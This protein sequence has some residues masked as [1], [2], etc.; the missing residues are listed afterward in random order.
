M[1]ETILVLNNMSAIETTT[2]GQGYEDL[3]VLYNLSTS[4]LEEIFVGTNLSEIDANQ[5]TSNDVFGWLLTLNVISGLGVL[6]NSLLAF[7]LISDFIVD[8]TRRTLTRHWLLLCMA[9]TNIAFLG[10]EIYIREFGHTFEQRERVCLILQHTDKTIEFVTVLYLVVVS[11]HVVGGAVRPQTGCG[12]KMVLFWIFFILFIM[13]CANL[14]IL[15]LFTMKLEHAFPETTKC[16]LDPTPALSR[17]SVHLVSMATFYIPYGLV[18]ILVLSSLVCSFVLQKKLARAQIYD[19]EF[20]MSRKYATIFL[21]ITSTTGFLLMLPFYL[22]QTPEIADM[23][24]SELQLE[25]LIVYFVTMVVKLV[26]YVL[27]PALCLILS[28]VRDI[29]KKL[30]GS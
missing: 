4:D 16:Q 5:D 23:F 25:F 29:Y 8:R 13:V 17:T 14:A 22:F 15:A 11:L 26:F 28:E 10:T 30:S 27:F 1:R 9:L 12:K 24:M 6:T 19:N 20:T 18:L 2:F 7:I 21:F 3:S